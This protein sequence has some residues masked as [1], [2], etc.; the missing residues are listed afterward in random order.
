MSDHLSEVPGAD[1]GAVALAARDPEQRMTELMELME[2]H[3]AA[4][5]RLQ[6]AHDTLQ[7]E[8]Q[9]LTVE[10]A[11]KN[12]LAV[13]GEMA[14]GMAHEIRN[15]LGGMEL[16]ASLLERELAD[17]PGRAELV[18]KIAT[19]IGYLNT[20]VDDMLAFTRLPQPDPR[21]TDLADLL[22]ETIQLAAARLQDNAVE[23]R[24]RCSPTTQL[25][26]DPTMIGRA[27][28]NLI[29][30]AADT[31]PGGGRVEVTAA[32]TDTERRQAR[33]TVRDTG[34]GL[35]SA[36]A[37]RIFE[38]FFTTKDH[39]TGLGL[40]IAQRII[41][42]HNGR[43]TAANH[44]EGGAVFEIVLQD[45]RQDPEG[46]LVPFPSSKKVPGPFSPDEA[47]QLSGPMGHTR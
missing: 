44:P 36:T 1:G 27:L 6:G 4:T 29:L 46:V 18:R 32:W 41:E 15:P 39:G 20:I 25:R 10:L 24:M 23:V 45:V 7:G 31:M 43:L 28:L 33:I 34:P 30:N 3:Q 12:R 37:Q 35:E 5:L 11:R 26:I 22:S 17:D 40:A 19:G 2:A 14:A 9:R 13:L 42:A 21:P 8:V 16:Y 47:K 38:P